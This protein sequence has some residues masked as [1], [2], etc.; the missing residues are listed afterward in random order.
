[1]SK[2][3]IDDKLEQVYCCIKESVEKFG[4]PPTVREIMS[5]IGVK[6]TST[7][8]YYLDILEENG[9]IKRGVGK[10]RSLELVGINNLVDSKI[11]KVALLG[12]VAAGQPIFAFSN[13]DEVYDLP[14]ELFNLPSVECF[15][16]TIKGD[17]M[18]KVGI[19]DRDKVVVRRQNYAENG[20]IVV[21]MIDGSATVKRYYKDGQVVRL[22]PENDNYEPIIS[23]EVVILGKV[24]GLVRKY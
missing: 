5:K 6:S 15:M 18:I 1:M 21:A 16:L 22:M 19:L 10:N 2:G 11:K 17:S 8:S 24:I 9:Q 23:K 7:I 13:Y 4:Y 20:E 14:T 3:K 12:D